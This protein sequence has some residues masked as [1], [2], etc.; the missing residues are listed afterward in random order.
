MYDLKKM[1]KE[2]E[3]LRKNINKEKYNNLK[4]L[5]DN[6]VFYKWA[7]END[8]VLYEDIENELYTN[9]YMHDVGMVYMEILQNCQK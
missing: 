7:F 9:K 6:D 1:K 2:I 4:I 8:D 5:N 3:K